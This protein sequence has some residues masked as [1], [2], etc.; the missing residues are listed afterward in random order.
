MGR[1]TLDLFS[2]TSAEILSILCTPNNLCFHFRGMLS[3]V[4]SSS[5]AVMCVFKSGVNQVHCILKQLGVEYW[6]NALNLI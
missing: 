1:W 3:Q 4:Y 6:T 5:N 2:I